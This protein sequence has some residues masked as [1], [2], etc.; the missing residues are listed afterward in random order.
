[1]AIITT[2]Y[3]KNGIKA[4]PNLNK[5]WILE[6]VESSINIYEQIYLRD[7]LGY[8]LY[9]LLLADM[10]EDVISERFSSLLDGAEYHSGSGLMK[11]GGLKDET[12]FESPIAYFVAFN[13]MRDNATQ[14]TGIGEQQSKST[15]A[16]VISQA[17]K[18]MQN[19]NAA[20]DLTVILVDF[21]FSSGLFPEFTGISDEKYLKIFT[22]F[23]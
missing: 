16:I 9:K 18:I 20:R 6:A 15:N 17:S 14:F 21:L 1:M 5:D 19:W 4:I 23:G 2:S 13:H 22:P 12:L 8:E 10:E 11:W 7:V 3:F